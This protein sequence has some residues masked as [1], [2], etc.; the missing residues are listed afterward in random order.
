MALAALRI[1][2]CLALGMEP[3]WER[4]PKKD[5][6]VW[7]L[8]GPRGTLL[9]SGGDR[10]RTGYVLGGSTGLAGLC[11]SLHSVTTL[12]TVMSPG[13]HHRQETL[14]RRPLERTGEEEEEDKEPSTLPL[15]FGVTFLCFSTPPWLGPLC[16]ARGGVTFECARFPRSWIKLLVANG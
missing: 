8:L 16:F 2:W 3:R 12:V 15:Y 9:E 13:G 4:N 6:R 1:R 7:S 5:E 11:S 14:P 10:L